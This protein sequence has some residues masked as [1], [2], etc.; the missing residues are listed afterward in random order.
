[1]DEVPR[2]LFAVGGRCPSGCCPTSIHVEVGVVLVVWGQWRRGQVGG[3]WVGMRVR[4]GVV[5][6][7]VV[8]SSMGV[9]AALV[10]GV[11]GG[12]WGWLRVV[13]VR[14]LE[15]G[16]PRPP[17]LFDPT[18]STTTPSSC[19]TVEAGGVHGNRA[20]NGA[21][22][23]GRAAWSSAQEA[24]PSGKTQHLPTARTPGGDN[25]TLLQ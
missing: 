14:L 10:Q 7:V 25:M 21:G 24:P 15:H 13:G 2:L 20:S 12:G 8:C 18:S 4:V 3:L 16:E 9:R 6:V 5:V 23:A 17:P 19:S 22:G 1:M 11:G